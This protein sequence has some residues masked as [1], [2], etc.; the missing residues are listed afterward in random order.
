MVFVVIYFSINIVLFVE[1]AYRHR[2]GGTIYNNSINKSQFFT[3]VGVLLAIA[4]GGGQCLNFNPVLLLILM[5]RQLI[6]KLRG[7]VLS[8]FLPLDHYIELHKLVGYMVVFFSM[9]HVIAHI[10]NFSE[11]GV[12][13]K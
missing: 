2:A 8:N 11:L 13:G 9:T 4:R 7:T 3:M 12:V 10:I 6:T 5:M 1:A